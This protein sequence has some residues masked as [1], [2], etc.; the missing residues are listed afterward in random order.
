[1]ESWFVLCTK[2]QREFQ[3]E[4]LFQEAGFPV[5]C[6]RFRS[7]GRIKPFFSC[8]EFLRFSY[9]EQYKLVKYTRGVRHVVGNDA[10]AVPLDVRFIEELRSREVGGL[11]ELEKY[12][13]EPSVGDEIEV[14]NGPWKGLRGVFQKHLS[15][16]DRVMILLNYVSYQGQLLIEKSKLKKVL[17]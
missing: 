3:V 11:I 16:R 8:Y 5:Y 1:M 10:G 6:P 13:V 17:T 12:G 14:V 4:R 9:P 7:A 2:S 15:D